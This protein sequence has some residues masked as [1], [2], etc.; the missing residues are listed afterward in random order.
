MLEWQEQLWVVM[1]EAD[2]CSS[3][4]ELL[5]NLANLVGD[6]TNIS[7]SNPEVSLL[8]EAGSPWVLHDE[9]VGSVSDIGYSM[10]TSTAAPLIVDSSEEKRM[11]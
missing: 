10:T 1:K 2:I 8:S 9:V 3:K 11:G 5:I 4:R 6:T 7:S